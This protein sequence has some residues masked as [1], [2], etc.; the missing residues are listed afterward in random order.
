MRRSNKLLLVVSLC[1]T[2]L[3]FVP[4][5]LFTDMVSAAGHVITLTRDVGVKRATGEHYLFVVM[6]LSHRYVIKRV[7]ATNYNASNND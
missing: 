2:L 1:L 4:N 6:V 5:Y 3:W 7:V